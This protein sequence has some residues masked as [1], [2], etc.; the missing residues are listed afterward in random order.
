MMDS[1]AFPSRSLLRAV[2]LALTWS[3]DSGAAEPYPNRPIRFM[4]PFAADQ[5]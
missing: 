3:V 1:R 2:L 4:V 5:S